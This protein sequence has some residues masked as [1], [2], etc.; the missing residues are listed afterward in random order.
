MSNR[1]NA[2]GLTELIDEL[3]GGAPEAQHLPI[4]IRVPG[5]DTPIVWARLSI[6]LIQD[7]DARKPYRALV[8]T[9]E[10]PTT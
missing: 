7:G 10:P 6:E 3:A 4:A 5:N 8:M 9:V 2:I 1:F